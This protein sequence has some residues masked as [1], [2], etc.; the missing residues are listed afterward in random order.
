MLGVT[1][2]WLCSMHSHCLSPSTAPV[3]TGVSP[4]TSSP[5]RAQPSPLTWIC[6][7]RR[8]ILCCC[9]ISCCCCLAI[10]QKERVG[11]GSAGVRPHDPT[12]HK[13]LQPHPQPAFHTSGR[14]G[15]TAGQHKEPAGQPPGFTLPLQSSPLE[16]RP[17]GW[18]GSSWLLLL[19]DP[20]HPPPWSSCKD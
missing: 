9:W 14:T 11:N 15:R 17:G 13:P 3:H 20:Q 1:P 18:A 5:P 7:C 10:W 4:S 2:E 8:L 19:R 16:T 6:C 12:S